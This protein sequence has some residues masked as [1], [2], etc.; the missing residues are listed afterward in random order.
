MWRFLDD[1]DVVL[2]LL[3]AFDKIL[4]FGKKLSES[5]GFEADP[6]LVKFLQKNG[7]NFLQT[8]QESNNVKIYDKAYIIA[9][10]YFVTEDVQKKLE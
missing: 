4:D 2:Q 6:L 7:A 10:M 3:D 8:M 9:D 1:N 5:E